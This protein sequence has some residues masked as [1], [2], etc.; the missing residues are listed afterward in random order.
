M[1]VDWPPCPRT[2]AGGFLGLSL[3]MPLVLIRTF[4]KS[5]SF[6]CA[7]TCDKA[8]ENRYLLRNN[9]VHT[10]PPQIITHKAIY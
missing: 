3:E 10:P 8:L 9:Y 4:Q 7:I 1:F 5:E 2:D 6:G